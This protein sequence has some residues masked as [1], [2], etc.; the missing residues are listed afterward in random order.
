MKWS[1]IAVVRSFLHTGSSNQSWSHRA[2]SHLERRRVHPDGVAGVLERQQVT[3]G[4]GLAVEQ[5]LHAGVVA[6]QP[7][8]IPHDEQGRC[9][10]VRE[11]VLAPG[12]GAAELPRRRDRDDRLEIRDH[13][14]VGAR[15]SRHE[16]RQ[17]AV[18]PGC[19]R[20]VQGGAG[21][22]EHAIAAHGVADQDRSLRI[23]GGETAGVRGGAALRLGG[24]EGDVQRAPRQRDARSGGV[25]DRWVLEPGADDDIAFGGEVL[26]QPAHRH[27]RPAVAVGQDD[28]GKT[29]AERRRVRGGGAR[30]GEGDVAAVLAGEGA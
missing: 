20:G 18:G 16:G 19:K 11:A 21:V 24:H 10:D 25:G 17:A 5:G 9:G 15:R 28:E 27:R 23:D 3:R 2:P 29:A 6:H 26:G 1:W 12:G 14:I 8:R 13:E 4:G 7:V 30:R 22:G